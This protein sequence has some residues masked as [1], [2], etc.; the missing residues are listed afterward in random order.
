VKERDVQ[1]A[2][3]PAVGSLWSAEANKRLKFGIDQEDDPQMY[4]AMKRVDR[5]LDKAANAS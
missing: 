2:D 5:V 4:R 1:K 3:N